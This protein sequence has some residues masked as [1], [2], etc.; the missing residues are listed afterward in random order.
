MAI[1]VEE[2]EEPRRSCGIA[3]VVK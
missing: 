3:L 1:V 2:E